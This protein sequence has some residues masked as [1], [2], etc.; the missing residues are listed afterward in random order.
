MMKNKQT[1][2]IKIFLFIIAIFFSFKNSI[3]QDL[4]GVEPI[5]SKRADMVRILGKE[6]VLPDGK[7]VFDTDDDEI[8]VTYYQNSCSNLEETKWKL[9]FDSVIE[10]KFIPKIPKHLEYLLQGDIK[11]FEKAEISSDLTVYSDFISGTIVVT[12]K[13][14]DGLEITESI[15]NLPS[16]TLKLPSCIT[17][18]LD[19]QIQKIIDKKKKTLPDGFDEKLFF[20][21]TPLSNSKP[22]WNKDTL[23][24]FANALRDSPHSIGHLIIYDSQ[25]KKPNRI[26]SWIKK[27]KLFLTKEQKIKPAQLNFIKGGYGNESMAELFVVPKTSEPPLV[28]PNKS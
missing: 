12:K 16:P 2:K 5:K 9:T 18:K 28:R 11:K 27:L 6:K 19:L 25:K 15:F 21:T 22:F 20:A 4:R 10:I 14:S 13:Q 7:S 23:L 17:T 3:S 26:K 24:R 1:M 8:V